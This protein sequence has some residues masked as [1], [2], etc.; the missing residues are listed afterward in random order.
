[1]SDFPWSD[2]WLLLSLIYAREPSDRKRLREIGDFINHAVFTA[3][4][5]RGGVRRLRAA[6]HLRR[7]GR[8]YTASEDVLGWYD[9]A[10]KGK[11]ST[12]VATDLR[13]VK[14]FLAKG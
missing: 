11:K 4:Q 12:Q 5:L 14:E 7:V 10:T 2:A 13:R 3:D 9:E 8:K 1:M 6:G